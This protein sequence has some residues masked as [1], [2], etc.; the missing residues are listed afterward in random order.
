MGITE[1]LA[2]FRRAGLQKPWVREEGASFTDIEREEEELTVWAKSVGKFLFPADL[3][4]G[5]YHADRCLGG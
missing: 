4:A 5:A 1:P 2:A 3:G